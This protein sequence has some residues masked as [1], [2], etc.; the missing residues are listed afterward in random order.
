MGIKVTNMKIEIVDPKS[1]NFDSLPDDRFFNE[2]IFQSFSLPPKIHCITRLI[3][4]EINKIEKI[5]AN[6]SE[7]KI[8]SKGMSVSIIGPAVIDSTTLSSLEFSL[9][10]LQFTYIEAL[11]NIIA[12]CT[13]RK[14]NKNEYLSS[15][16][17]DHLH[18]R[19]GDYKKGKVKYKSSF[20]RIED[21]IKDYLELL[22]KVNNE[23]Y[24]FDKSSHYW[25]GFKLAKKVRDEI[26]HPRNGVRSNFDREA[27]FKM[28]QFIYWYT[29]IVF[30]KFNVFFDFKNYKMLESAT[31]ASLKLMNEIYGG[32]PE[33]IK[34]FISKHDNVVVND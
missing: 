20:V 32:N 22:C 9:L 27:L 11:C 23:Q 34:D 3:K 7:P 26:A 2:K 18:E 31:F 28:S 25:E 13:L 24:K 33:V 17:I 8:K 12:E 21:K 10:L 6:A 29:E 15:I 14:S 30:S 19:K 4:S 1:V 16:E 5:A